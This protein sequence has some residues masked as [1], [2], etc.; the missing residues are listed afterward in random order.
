MENASTNLNI[1]LSEVRAALPILE[2][3]AYF[4]TGTIGVMARP[5]LDVYLDSIERFQSRGW[6]MWQD[7]I[8][9]TERGRARLA[10]QIGAIPAEIT[11]TRNATD[12][13]NH[14][15]AGIEWRAGDEVIIS[16][17]EHPALLFP[18]T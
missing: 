5:V 7:M 13:A 10:A 3:T 1:D 14:V 15:A 17:Q 8:E 12:G 18:W 16:D 2:E 4:N 11:L 6:V 9:A